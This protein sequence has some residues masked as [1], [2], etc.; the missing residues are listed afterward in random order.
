M[1]GEKKLMII[2]QT[3]SAGDLTV[4]GFSVMILDRAASSQDVPTLSRKGI[5]TI[6]VLPV[7]E[8]PFSFRVA[9]DLSCP[10]ESGRGSLC[11]DL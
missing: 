4:W 10:A 8:N 6:S 7:S 2:L 11:P 1:N 5:S 9:L 3:I